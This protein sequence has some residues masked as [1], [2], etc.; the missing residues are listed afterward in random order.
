MNLKEY[1]LRS[2][3]TAKYRI[4]SL[5]PI[6]DAHMDIIEKVLN[7]YRPKDVTRPKKLMF[8]TNPLGFTGAKNV[9]IWFIDVE[10]TVPVAAKLLEYDLEEKLGLKYDSQAI[11]VVTEDDPRDCCMDDDK[12]ETDEEGKALLLDPEYKE[13]QPIDADDYSG[14]AYNKKLTDY[15][16]KIADEREHNPSAA[17]KGKEGQPDFDKADFN[18][19]VPVEKA[20]FSTIKPLTK[21]GPV[22]KKKK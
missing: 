16:K 21:G 17:A 22:E 6:T 9:E 10:L 7:K 5:R 19:G 12:E 11:Q 14:S 3:K 20:K 15:M 1:L 18:A 13:V 8:Q 2:E 4:K